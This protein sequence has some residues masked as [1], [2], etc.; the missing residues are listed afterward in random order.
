MELPPYPVATR[1][2]P[3][4]LRDRATK[5]RTAA[6]ELREQIASTEMAFQDAFEKADQRSTVQDRIAA[7]AQDAKNHP[8]K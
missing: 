3:S 8:R 2:L 1:N 4:R 6:N 7:L 5:L